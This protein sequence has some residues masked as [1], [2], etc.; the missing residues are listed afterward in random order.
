MI[1]TITQEDKMPIIIRAVDRKPKI[2]D[3][4]WDGRK[5]IRD[6]DFPFYKIESEDDIPSQQMPDLVV[7]WS[8]PQI[9]L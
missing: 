5:E 7:D 3:L 6:P 8:Y 1:Q 9:K 2:G 4:M